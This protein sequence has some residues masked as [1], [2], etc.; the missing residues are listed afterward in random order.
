MWNQVYNPLGN[1]ALSTVAAAVPVVTLLV[2]IASGKV[3]AHVAA[4]IAVIVTNLIAILVFTMPAA[5]SIRASLLGI[6]TGFFPIGWIVLNVIFLYQITVMTGK[7][8][9]LKRAVGGV[10]EDRRLQLL[11][12]AFSFGAFFEGASGFGTPVAITGSILIGL[13]FSPLAASGLSLIANTAPVAYGALGTPIQGLAS[14]TGLDP[15]ILGAMVGRQLPFFSLIVPF[16]VVWAFAGWRGMK[17]VW[18]A[19]LVTGVSFAIPQFVI[20]NYINPWIVDIGASL[21]SMGSLILF[22][23]IW[24]P[25]ELWLSPALRGRDESAATMAAAKP[26]DKAPLTQSEL[27]SALLPWIIVCIVMLI[28]GNGAFKTWANSIFTW[29]YAVPDLHNMINKMPPVVAKPTPEGAVFSFTY[30]SFTGTG[31]L[32]AAIISGFLMGLSPAKLIA[33]YGRTIRLCAI[34]L[35]TISAMLAIGTLTRLG[36]VDATLGLA[37]AATGVLYP[38]FGTLLGWLGV[39]LTGSDTSSNILFGNLQKITSQ[40]LG[41]SPILMAAANSSGGVMG[42]MID[43]QSIVVASTATNWYGHEGSILRYVFKHSIV[44]ACLVGILVTLQAY[45]YPFTLLVLK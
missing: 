34:S 30:L 3:K 6:V 17:D 33:E 38:F 19:I 25:R 32:I 28:W 27:W 35:I 31:M 36:G 2:L 23:R 13:G 12:V 9:L 11:L 42:K 18:P 15:Y 8:E 37:F 14:V 39:A 29:N 10:T 43:A 26:L 41:L 45:V 1:A 44:L 5:M 21:I 22:L 20:S 40:Q 16:W 24:Q 4:I 7:F